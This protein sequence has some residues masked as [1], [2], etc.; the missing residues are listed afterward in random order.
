MNDDSLPIMYDMCNVYTHTYIIL[1]YIVRDAMC[2]FLSQSFICNTFASAI[3][4]APLSMSSKREPEK[5]AEIERGRET[6]IAESTTLYYIF[7]FHHYNNQ[8]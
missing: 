2:S 4:S 1:Y 8:L 3:I 5:Q 7:Q 6:E